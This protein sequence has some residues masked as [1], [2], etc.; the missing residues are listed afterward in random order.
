MIPAQG[1]GVHVLLRAVRLRWGVL[2]KPCSVEFAHAHMFFSHSGEMY[3]VA[4]RKQIVQ[5]KSKIN[6]FFVVYSTWC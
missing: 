5:I 4:V 2:L 3:I 1:T 6:I